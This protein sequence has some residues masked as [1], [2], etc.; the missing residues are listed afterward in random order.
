P[1]STPE[2]SVPSAAAIEY[3]RQF[4][5]ILLD[6]YQ[7]T[8]MVQEAI[9]SLLARPGAGNR[10]M[11]GDVKQSIYRFRLAEPN[12]F[13]QKYKS[14]SS[15]IVEET[16]SYAAAGV[17][18]DLARNF[19]SRSE[20]VEGVNGVFRSIMREK[21]A[22]MDYD[23]RAELVCG[24]DYPPA[25][26]G[27]PA[28]RYDVEFALID[29]G[30][31]SGVKDGE[32]A[33][34]GDESEDGP[35]SASP[36]GEEALDLQT[37][38]LE[39]RYI[40]A[41]IAKLKGLDSALGGGGAP[42]E[43]Y[44]GKRRRKRVLAWRDIVILLRADKQWAPVIIEELQ[45]SG[46]PAYAELSTGYFE[47]T[48]VETILSLL[49]VIDN[50]YQDIP[51]AGALRSPIFGLTAEELAQIRI[52]GGRASYYDAV[53]KAAGA[54]LIEETTRIKLADFLTRLERWREES[55]RGALA[56][57]LWNI[58]RETGYYDLVGGMP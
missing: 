24:A 40:A 56:E 46:I 14:Y 17:R 54:S 7:D 34:A 4:D 9:V 20:V 10:F 22:E 23:E 45:S 51:L 58:F 15:S 55:R 26:E 29:K 16:G 8:N 27:G 30:G 5:E 25:A 44:D 38:Q 36:S 49:R 12:L 41:Q 1:A 18:I 3:Q 21:V 47:A 11:V 33:F 6:E 43:V 52:I 48:E 50:P 13:L 2:L 28:E 39:A 53:K 35:D 31:G 37:V 32:P 19:R 57:L 42:F